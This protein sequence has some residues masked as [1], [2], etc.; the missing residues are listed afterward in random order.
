[1][2]VD[3]DSRKVYV[4]IRE[5]KEYP[6]ALTACRSFEPHG[7]IVWKT[8][9]VAYNTWDENYMVG[10]PCSRTPDC[11]QAVCRSPGCSCTQ[12]LWAYALA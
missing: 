8:H 2:L 3:E 9:L 7:H 4:H 11:W 1:M 10:Q 12:A 5:F 6:G